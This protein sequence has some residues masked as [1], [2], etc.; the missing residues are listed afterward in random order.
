[1]EGKDSM[2]IIKIYTDGACAGNQNESNV[3]GWGAILEYGEHR[4]ELY[5]GE[6]NTT[7]NRMEMKALLEALRAL[8]KDDMIVHCFSDSSYL[9]ECFVKKWYLK[10]QE[11][12][13]LTSSKTPVENKELWEALLSEINRQKKIRFF[14]VKGHL[15][16]N[17]IKDMEKWFAKFKE[18]N[19][20][21][22]TMEDFIYCTKMN[23]R[24]DELAN[25]G[26]DQVR[27]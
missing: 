12:G 21:D 13:W 11:N 1:M 18:W 10:W 4:K 6:I 26:I 19:G 20:K 24:A 2:K 15:N 5:G 8:K 17:N 23:I 9:I 22:F 7:N 14:R 16:L 27:N 3:G 25:M